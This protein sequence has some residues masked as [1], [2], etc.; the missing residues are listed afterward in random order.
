M[1]NTPDGPRLTKE[2]NVD[3]SSDIGCLPG[4]RSITAM[5]IDS[6]LL[7]FI[8]QITVQSIWDGDIRE[9]ETI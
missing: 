9:P 1:F 8:E 7:V 6:Q 2:R 5:D 3:I 4:E